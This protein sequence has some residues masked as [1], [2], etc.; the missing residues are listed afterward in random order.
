MVKIKKQIIVTTSLAEAEYI[1]AREATKE[2]VAISS[3]TKSRCQDSM[4][5][6]QN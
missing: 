4:S 5:R 2:M 1:S 3:I 6:F